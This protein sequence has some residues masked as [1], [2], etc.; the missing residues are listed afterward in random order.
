MFLNR[1]PTSTQLHL[2]PSTSI[3]LH[4]P[5]PNSFQPP[6][7]SIHLHP[8]LCNTLNIIRTKYPS[9]WAFSPNLGRKNRSCSFWLKTRTYGILEVLIANPDLDFWKSDPEIHFWA[10]FGPKK[11]KLSVLPKNLHAWY[12]EDADSYSDISFLNLQV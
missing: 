11:S 10:N 9:N 5:P 8:A 2:P 1:A 4:P 3:Q 12:L 6:P 7:S